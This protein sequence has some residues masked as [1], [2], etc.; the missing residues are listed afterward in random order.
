MVSATARERESTVAPGLPCLTSRQPRPAASRAEYVTG[1]VSA[2]RQ[3]YHDWSQLAERCAAH[4][5][6]LPTTQ[7][8]YLE[9][10]L[11]DARIAML[12]VE[13]NG[14][15][16]GAMPLVSDRGRLVHVPVRRLRV[17][18]P[19]DS[20]DRFDILCAADGSTEVATALWSALAARHDW[21][22]I[23]L[24]DLPEGGPGWQLLDLARYAGFGIGHR[25]SRTTPCMP[26]N[27]E[28][29]VEANLPAAN[30]KFRADLR[31]CWRN[32]EK[33]GPVE[34]HRHVEYDDALFTRFLEM[35]HAG[36]KGRNGTSILSDPIATAHHRRLARA[37]GENG[38][39]VLYS[40]ECAGEP[41]AM[42]FGM[43]AGGTYAVP[44]LTYDERYHVFAPGQLI[45]WEV[46]RDLLARGFTE[47]DFLGDTAPWKEKW[48]DHRRVLHRAHIFNQTLAGRIARM[49]RYD[50]APRGKALS[51]RVPSPRTALTSW[52]RP[53]AQE[54]PR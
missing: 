24:V 50:V 29:S 38:S 36:W 52:I 22:V 25:V 30:T 20:P 42:H 44:K 15:L 16:I 32:L 6:L 39:L 1:P 46:L 31:R 9:T 11:P 51:R 4:P 12:T 7:L 53:Q 26:L 49:A 8:A 19:L 18:G 37:A 41:I 34:F 23:E 3:R 17:P 43:V 10:M 48:T 13:R 27:P 47:F 2:L 21:D 35:E 54:A 14:T 28:L 40:L 5:S 33:R 45:V